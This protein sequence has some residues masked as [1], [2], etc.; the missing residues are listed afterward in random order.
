MTGYSMVAIVSVALI[1]DACST[2]RVRTSAGYKN[3]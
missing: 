3:P 2:G 1:A